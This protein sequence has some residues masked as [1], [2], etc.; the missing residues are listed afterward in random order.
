MCPRT[1]LAL[2]LWV[3]SWHSDTAHTGADHGA[4]AALMAR[5][6]LAD[7]G[8]ILTE[9]PQAACQ[10]QKGELVARGGWCGTGT[11]KGIPLEHPH[12]S[13]LQPSA[14]PS[15]ASVAESGASAL[16][17]AEARRRSKS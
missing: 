2:A 1:G 15:P 8:R 16:P 14:T 10:W 11:A 13:S 12:P 7:A 4:L 9:M 5:A 17:R 6:P 3:T